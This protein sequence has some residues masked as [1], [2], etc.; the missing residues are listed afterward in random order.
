MGTAPQIEALSPGEENGSSPANNWQIPV[1]LASIFLGVLVS[2][3]FRVQT[4]KSQ[5]SKQ[6]D[7]MKIIKDLEEQRNKLTEDLRG[8]RERLTEIEQKLGKGSEEA[9]ELR[10]QAF[11]AK[12][13]AGLTSM[14]GPGLAITLT[15]S[16]RQPSADEDIHYFIIHDV[17]LQS[18]VNE[19]Y[20][21]GAE[22]VSIN[23]QRIVNR[24]PIRCVGPTI[25]IDTNRVASPYVVTAIGS[26]ANMEGGLRMTGGFLDSMN[27]LIRSGGQVKL[28]RGNDLKV[29]A[30][31]GSLKLTY[32]KPVNP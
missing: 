32:A 9:K 24:T 31:T 1:A 11:D 25:L 20:A 17:D 28:T 15:D 21:S 13:N 30:Y 26:P 7:L 18:L 27:M 22:A 29:P 19:L 8:S 10:E 16:I 6:G 2:L 4:V 23:G 3:Q 14:S 5:P 12:V